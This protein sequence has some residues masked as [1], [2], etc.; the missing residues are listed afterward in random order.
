MVL[1]V[2]DDTRRANATAQL[3][4]MLGSVPVIASTEPVAAKALPNVD[5]VIG[6]PE[7]LGGR[8]ANVLYA[9]GKLRGVFR[10]LLSAHDVIQ[11]RG[12][13][14]WMVHEPFTAIALGDLLAK[15]HAHRR[16]FATPQHH[17][18]I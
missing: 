11:Q 12:M 2:D 8:A 7:A 18:L 1:I 4:R 5:V 14:D 17:A 3:V 15:A 9:A 6:S 16:A 13:A 10:V